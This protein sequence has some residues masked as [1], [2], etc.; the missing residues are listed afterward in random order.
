M[1][2]HNPKLL[3]KKGNWSPKKIGFVLFIF[4]FILI[5]VVVLVKKQKKKNQSLN[6]SSSSSYQDDDHFFQKRWNVSLFEKVKSELQTSC[7]FEN[8]FI[9]DETL[10]GFVQFNNVLP[11]NT[12]FTIVVD[13]EEAEKKKSFLSSTTWQ[14]ITSTFFESLVPMITVVE[15]ENL[16]DDKDHSTVK[17]LDVEFERSDIFPL[18]NGELTGE[19]TIPIK[20]P[21]NPNA[22]LDKIYKDYDWKVYCKSMDKI[23]RLNKPI[24]EVHTS[25]WT[26]VKY[27]VRADDLFKHVY[28]INLDKRTDRWESTIDKLDKIGIKNGQ[29][30]TAIDADNDAV[31]EIYSEIF[32]KSSPEHLTRRELACYLSHYSL[33]AYLKQ[34]EVDYALILEDDISMP[35]VTG[36]EDFQ[37]VLDESLGFNILFFGHCLTLGKDLKRR[38]YDHLTEK[39]AGLCLHAYAVSKLG[40]ENLIEY[41]NSADV[42]RQADIVTRNFCTKKLCYLSHS[43]EES[44]QK[45][46]FSE[47]IVVQDREK[48]GSDIGLAD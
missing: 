38:F 11:W 4:L 3:Q 33:W 39:G 36:E 22:V 1:S 42:Q 12:N 48:L 5:A 31:K 17:I 10:L 44:D 46:Y 37:R 29:K 47:G 32:G 21:N 35:G 41:A 13:A 27:P 25:T 14:N 24:E 19:I 8:Y 15:V 23:K 40:I 20:Y 28:I 9:F 34:K 18:K 26:Q 30:W 7:K 2:D 43:Y 16:M 45:Q 6:L